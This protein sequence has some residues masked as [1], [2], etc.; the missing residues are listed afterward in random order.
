MAVFAVQEFPFLSGRA[1]IEAR[2]LA[3]RHTRQCAFPC[4]FV[5]TF[6]EVYI[7][8]MGFSPEWGISLPIWR[9]FH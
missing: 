4:F 6:I 8:Y 5:G 2:T 3:A 9:G 1:F 7:S